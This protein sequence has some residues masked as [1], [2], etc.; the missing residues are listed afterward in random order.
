MAKLVGL[1]AHFVY[2]SVMGHFN[3]VPLEE[4]H[5]KQLF[6]SMLQ[7]VSMIEQKFASNKNQKSLFVNFVMPIIILTIR[8]QIE[9]M[10][11]MHFRAFLGRIDKTKSNK[12]QAICMRLING[13]ITE[14]FDPNIFFSRLSFLE[15]GKD[16]LDIKNNLNQGRAHNG[17]K[18]PNIKDKFY[19][20]SAL[21]KN[22]IP[23]PSEGKMRSKFGES[24]KITYPPIKL[25][26]N[27]IYY[28]NPVERAEN[29]MDYAGASIQNM[30]I[31]S[32]SNIYRQLS[33]GNTSP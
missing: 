5:M 17:F 21:V 3:E 2:W 30:N 23:L 16:A 31:A 14:V 25:K 28:K 7:I 10:Y 1:C 15:S 33:V 9:M 20:R 8:V 26:K 6:I 4:Y 32:E 27:S 19:T 11:K 13:V 22:L 18:L 12:H 29:L 24:R